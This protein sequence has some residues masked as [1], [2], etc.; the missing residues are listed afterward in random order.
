MITCQGNV[1]FQEKTY[2]R[3]QEDEGSSDRSKAGDGD[4]G[5]RGGEPHVRLKAANSSNATD[6][7]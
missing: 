4:I 7:R 1:P 3:P 2:G 6:R 5:S